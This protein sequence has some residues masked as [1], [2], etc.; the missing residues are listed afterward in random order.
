MPKKYN[1]FTTYTKYKHI[2]RV[3]SGDEKAEKMLDELIEKCLNYI[4]IVCNNEHLIAL[5]AN[6]LESDNYREFIMKLDKNRTSAHNALISSLHSFN[7]YI[8][9][10]Y[11]EEVPVGGIYS[12]D[13]ITIR[14]RVAIANW[15]MELVYSIFENRSL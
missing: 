13:P 6:R 15:A 2:L 12:Y 5:K 10:E 3:I 1:N 14:N 9:K 11:D 4:S 7:R 8:I